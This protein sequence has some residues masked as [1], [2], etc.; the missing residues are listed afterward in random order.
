M[1]GEW[2]IAA[3][4]PKEI[5]MVAM[6]VK[7]KEFLAYQILLVVHLGFMRL[8]P[9]VLIFNSSCEIELQTLWNLSLHSNF[10]YLLSISKL[11]DY[12]M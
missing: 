11:Y 6:Y 2:I 9:K 1:Q 8:D 5:F 4:W 10:F 3:V 12:G 7:G